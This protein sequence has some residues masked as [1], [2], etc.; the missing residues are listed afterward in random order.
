MTSPLVPVPAPSRGALG[1]QAEVAAP[2]TVAG[3]LELPVLQRGRPEVLSGGDLHERTVRWVHTSEIYDIAPLLKGGEVLLTTGLGLVGAGPAALYEY[4]ASLAERSVAAMVLELGRTFSR[5]P[6]ELVDGAVATG[7]PLITLRGIVP[8]VEITETVHALLIS[9]EVARLRLAQQVDT[10]MTA[11]VL[12]GGGLIAILREA[13]ALAACPVRL[14]ADDGH[15]VAASDGPA[16]IADIGGADGAFPRAAVELS[17][18]PWGDLLVCGPPT[19]ARRLIADR[20]ATAV[21]LELGRA[22]GSGGSS[23]RRAGALLLRNIFGRQYSSTDEIIGRAAALGI[24]VRPGGRAWGICLAVDEAA[25]ARGADRPAPRTSPGE[26]P[27]QAAAVIAAAESLLGPV[28][29]TELDGSYLIATAAP[30]DDPRAMMGALADAVDAELSAGR[31]VAV[32]CGPPV[33]DIPAIARSLRAAREASV[34]ARRLHSEM[35]VLL[36]TD[37][38]VQRLLSRFATDPELA[39]FVDEQLGP[40]LDYDAAHG[41]DLVRTLDALLACGLSKAEAARRLHIR[42]QTLYQRLGTISDLLGG[43]DLDAR[44]RRTSIDLA[45][46]G[47]RLRTAGGANPAAGRAEPS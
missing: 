17:S 45:L 16:A 5:A 14:Y 8:F 42:R 26:G 6:E 3:M 28:L 2:L 29:A 15:L 32:T 10:V 46:V 11:A 43:L 25:S 1:L 40:L 22:G 37:L 27:N 9:G 38:G 41:R 35:R 19:M 23:R 24:S 34:L 30:I 18:R 4:A 7:L 33:A 31:A 47:W 36:A 20:T 12:G 44:E 21:A 13:A 39:A